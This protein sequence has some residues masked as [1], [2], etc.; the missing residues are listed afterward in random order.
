MHLLIRLI[1]NAIAFYLIAKYLNGFNHDVGAGTAIVAALVFGLVNA[2]IRPIVLL[3][4]LPINIITIG[5]FTIIVNALMFWLT[6]TFVPSIKGPDFGFVPA[7]IGAIIMMV[8]SFILSHIFA[9]E[10][11]R[12]TTA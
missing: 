12:R 4:T 1:I 11:E 6:A 3:I 9:A 5:L 2:I 7:L 8:V 10:S